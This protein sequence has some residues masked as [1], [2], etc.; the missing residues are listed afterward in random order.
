MHGRL[1]TEA[2]WEYAATSCGKD[3]K[4]FPWG[5]AP[6]FVPRQKPK[7]NIMP[8]FAPVGSAGQEDFIPF[9]KVG[10]FEKDETEQHVFDLAGNVSELCRDV[11]EPYS[12]LDLSANSKAQPLDDPGQR[13]KSQTPEDKNFYVVRGGSYFSTERK[14]RTFYRAG[15]KG[16]E[17]PEENG[18]RIVIECPP[19]RERSE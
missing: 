16:A 15:V 5:D 19:E 8:Q 6:L 12:S 17:A 18:F 7:A 11:Y 3:K 2:Q 1:P 9:L 14:A 4:P 13:R 10:S